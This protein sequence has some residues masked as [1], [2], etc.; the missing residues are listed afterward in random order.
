MLKTNNEDFQEQI[1]NY[2]QHLYELKSTIENYE[3]Q[4]HKAQHLEVVLDD[5]EN[6]IVILREEKERDQMI[7]DSM[8]RKIRFF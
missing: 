3:A 5:L 6:K 7:I 2:N 1:Q 4:I 8:A